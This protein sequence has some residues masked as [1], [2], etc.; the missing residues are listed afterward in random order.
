MQSIESQLESLETHQLVHIQKKIKTLIRKK[1]SAEKK[2]LIEEFKKLATASGLSISDIAWA[3]DGK[4]VRKTRTV[5][6]S[7]RSF[8]NP[9]NPDQTWTG[10]GRQPAWYIKAKEAGKTDD[11]LLA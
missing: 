1:K 4:K 8:K 11:E 2:A 6:P 7:T 3:D 5:A 10:R 9:E